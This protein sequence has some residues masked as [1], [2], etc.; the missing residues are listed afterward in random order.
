MFRN[1]HHSLRHTEKKKR[2]ETGEWDEVS[3]SGRQLN[4]SP[5]Y[6]AHTRSRLFHSKS[7]KKPNQQEPKHKQRIL[8]SSIV[9]T[10]SITDPS[11]TYD[12]SGGYFQCPLSKITRRQQ[13]QSIQLTSSYFSSSIGLIVCR[14]SIH[15]ACDEPR[16][17]CGGGRNAHG[18]SSARAE[19]AVFFP[20]DTRNPN[21][22]TKSLAP[23]DA[24]AEEKRHDQHL[25]L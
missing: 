2:E 1:N 7:P 12:H 21:K 25:P 10:I 17:V 3:A 19:G 22:N 13:P 20:H 24:D 4:G 14:F 23:R 18:L 8:G 5:T 9:F 15:S 16:G 11:R 6:L